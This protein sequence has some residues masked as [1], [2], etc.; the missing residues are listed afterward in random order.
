MTLPY[1]KSNVMSGFKSA[2]VIDDASRYAA[3]IK[4]AERPLLVV[5]P[6]CLSDTLDGRPLLE[7]AL[8]IAQTADIPICATAHTKKELLARGYTPESSYD[9]IEIFHSLTKP[10]WQGVKG[11]GNHDL[12]LFFGIRSDLA[13]GGLSTLKHYAPHLKTM[14]L[15]KYYFPH[16]DYSMPNFFKDEKWRQFLTNMIEELRNGA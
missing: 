3:L 1:H 10:T 15:C 16:A 7:W 8:E 4:K 2:R 9:L 11:E 14:T 6:R 13:S 5:G 12:V